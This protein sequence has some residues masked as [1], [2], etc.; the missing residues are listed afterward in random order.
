M[1]AS[2]E[3]HP[4]QVS[5]T[6]LFLERAERELL[7]NAEADQAEEMADDAAEAEEEAVEA[8]RLAA[9]AAKQVNSDSLLYHDEG[10]ESNTTEKMTSN[11]HACVIRIWLKP[12]WAM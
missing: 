1:S 7:E 2:D 3:N 10:K 12:K 8:A 9:E 5:H 6:H 11:K 4:L